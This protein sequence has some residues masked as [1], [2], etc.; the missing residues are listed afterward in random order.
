MFTCMAAE[1]QRS[2]VCFA[3]ARIITYAK[4][5]CARARECTS[6]SLVLSLRQRHGKHDRSSVI[7]FY[8]RSSSVLNGTSK[9]RCCEG[10][11][12]VEPS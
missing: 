2:S 12:Q 10:Q 8:G 4:L 7:R 3:H 9:A 6:K 5:I 1:D 11:H